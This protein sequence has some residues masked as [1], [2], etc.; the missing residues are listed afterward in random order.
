[1]GQ[2]NIWNPFFHSFWY[3]ASCRDYKSLFLQ[4]NA[5]CRI[6]FCVLENSSL[7]F[8]EFEVAL[9]KNSSLPFKEF[10]S[11]LLKNWSW[12][13][14]EFKLALLKNSSLPYKEFKYAFPTNSGL[15]FRKCKIAFPR[16]QDCTS[17]NWSLHF[18]N[19]ALNRI[20]C[21]PQYIC[22]HVITTY[23]PC[24]PTH[25]QQTDFR[26]KRIK[27]RTIFL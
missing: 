9:L 4:K 8:Y 16:V 6:K 23:T 25:P 5:V 10:K 15:R 12:P 27:R 14:K 1:M 13:F 7:L 11:A 18:K 24:G 17:K 22:T 2:G 21:T 20:H 26:T 19:R 3:F